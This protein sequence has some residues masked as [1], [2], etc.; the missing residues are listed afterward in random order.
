MESLTCGRQTAG[1]VDSVVEGTTDTDSNGST[2]TVVAVR[3]RHLIPAP[4][5]TPSL[6]LSPPPSPCRT[7]IFHNGVV[8]EFTE[9]D[10]PI[11]PAI[12]FAENLALLNQMWDDTPP[13][14]QGNSVLAIHGVPIPIV[15]WKNIYSR[16]HGEWKGLKSNWSLWKA[17]FPSFPNRTSC[18][19]VTAHPDDCYAL[20]SGL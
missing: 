3:A 10:I 11:P 2:A 7:L 4:P 18:S 8:L 17:C 16:L 12:S 20:A 6:F 5:P 13:H 19:Q 1:T 14:W 15:Y 9:E